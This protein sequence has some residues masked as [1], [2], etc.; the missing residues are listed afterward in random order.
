MK[1]QI[2]I[3]AVQVPALEKAYLDMVSK[4]D[5]VGSKMPEANKEKEMS[6]G[7]MLLVECTIQDL[8]DLM[9]RTGI[10]YAESLVS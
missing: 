5:W 10:A 1:H 6:Y 4:G 3:T 2:F 8:A 9:T 7:T